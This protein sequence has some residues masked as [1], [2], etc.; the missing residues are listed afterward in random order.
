MF[1]P[2]LR[3]ASV[4]LVALSCSLLALSTSARAPFDGG[5]DDDHDHD[6]RA[7]LVLTATNDAAGNAVVLLLRDADGRLNP[8]GSFAT[9]GAGTGAGLGNQGGMTFDESG[10]RLLVVNAGSDDVSVLEFGRHGMSV[11]DVEGAQGSQPISVAQHGDL[12]YVLNAGG[13]G[14]IAGF[15]MDRRGDLDPICD[16]Q[17]PLSGSGTGPAQIGFTPDGKFL[18]VTEKATNTLVTYR[19]GRDGRP[20]DPVVS[21]S[22]GMTPFGFSFD[23]RGRILTSDAAGGMAGLSTVSSYEIRRD[24][25]L[26]TITSAL[27]TTQS[28]A[29]WLVT[30]PDGRFAYVT[31]AA[32]NTVTGLDV[33][34]RGRLE[35]LEPSGATGMTGAGPIDAAITRNGRFLYVLDS[36]DQAISAFRIGRHGELDPIDFVDGLSTSANGLAAL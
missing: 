26:E 14:G 17:R 28:A 2:R 4:P 15:H 25:R 8:A 12:V 13:D 30:T 16:S 5:D 10:R 9:G 6:G 7:G 34:R 18:V 27:P 11:R 29:C 21:P 35:L 20:G 19:M 22:A 3:G 23:H 24:G 36:G 1:L 33:D 32:S 31:N